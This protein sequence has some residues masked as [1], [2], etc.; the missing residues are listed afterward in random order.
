ML[1]DGLRSIKRFLLMPPCSDC[2]KSVCS[3]SL[4]RVTCAALPEPCECRLETVTLGGIHAQRVVVQVTDSPTVV[5]A[6][7]AL[8]VSL[9]LRGPNLSF[10]LFQFAL[11]SLDDVQVR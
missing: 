3:E 2:L 9:L 7:A 6:C 1:R 8:S 10:L 11:V 5:P 4:N